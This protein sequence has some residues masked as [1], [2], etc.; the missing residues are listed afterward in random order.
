MV[1]LPDLT[2]PDFSTVA[3]M[4]AAFCALRAFIAWGA[5]NG[6][7]RDAAQAAQAAQQP[8][9]TSRA[10]LGASV[11]Q[12]LHDVGV[13]QHIVD[14]AS[15]VTKQLSAQASPP[16][17]NSW[18]SSGAPYLFQLSEELLHVLWIF[19][20]QEGSSMSGSTGSTSS[21]A[22]AAAGFGLAL[23]LLGFTDGAGQ[24][25]ACCTVHSRQPMG[26]FACSITAPDGPTKKLSA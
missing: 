8:A 22:S 20:L 2:G 9:G 6:L 15:A 12:Q 3:V 24:S 5:V 25:A 4:S 16:A 19:T 26:P 23:A 11:M 10:A 18:D 17:A 1:E 13:P 14:I 7:F 21:A